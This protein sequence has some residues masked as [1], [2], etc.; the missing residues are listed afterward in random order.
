[1]A[2]HVIDV[3]GEQSIWQTAINIHMFHAAATLALAA[4]FAQMNSRFLQ[5][6]AWSIVAGTSVFCGS[7]Y[8]H[9]MTG[10]QFSVVAPTGGL[11]MIAG[12]VLTIVAFS[13]KQ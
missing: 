13:G 8:L 4:L 12:W 2:S 7:I 11:L 10:H 5:W 9:V 3:Q 1:M 6:G